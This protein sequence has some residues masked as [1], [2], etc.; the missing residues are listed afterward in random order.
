MRQFVSSVLPDA[1]GCIEVRG[2]DDVYLRRVLRL[3]RGAVLDVRLPDGRLVRGTLTGTT[4]SSGMTLKVSGEDDNGISATSKNSS[5][6][7]ARI[8]SDF[9]RETAF[10][11]FQFLPKVQKFDIVVRQ[12]VETGVTALV[13]LLGEYSPAG[14]FTGRMERFQR[15]V[16]EARQQSGSPIQTEL[17]EPLTVT[18]A[19][20]W[21]QAHRREPAVAV[22]ISEHSGEGNAVSLHGY[23]K[24]VP[25][26]AAIAVGSEGGVSP[27]E[28][29]ALI[30]AGFVP[31][32]FAVNVLRVET[33]ALYGIAAVQSA[34][35]EYTSWHVKE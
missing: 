11:L 27:A 31:V 30:N 9:Y 34:V 14:N 19:M 35:M 23:I 24:Y 2:K 13:P 26:S 15:I 17:L 4:K 6:D 21:W 5:V 22:L 20:D 8:E 33:A 16:K 3:T 18:D 32:H 7:A 28:R 1:N 29:E 25:A 12:A 10:Y